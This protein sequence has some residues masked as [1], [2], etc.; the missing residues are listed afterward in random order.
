MEIKFGGGFIVVNRSKLL[1]NI[2]FAPKQD[3]EADKAKK[4]CKKCFIINRDHQ[5]EIY[6]LIKY[7][8]DVVGKQVQV[9]E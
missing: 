7:I 4:V 3:I 1:E 9:F 5:G 2:V 8:T 6:F